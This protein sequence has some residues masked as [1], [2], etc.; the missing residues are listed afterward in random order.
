LPVRIAG[1]V[2][3]FDPTR[4]LPRTAIRWL[5]P[6]AHYAVAAAIE[7]IEAAKLEVDPARAERTGVLVGTAY[8]PMQAVERAMLKFVDSGPDR[9]SPFLA[10]VAA[11]NSSHEIAR[12]LGAHGPSSSVTTACA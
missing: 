2:R 8:G 5:D 4:Y 1:E 12:R 10:A 9:V 3:G 7:A 11:D 6:S